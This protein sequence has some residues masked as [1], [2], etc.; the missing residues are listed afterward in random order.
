MGVTILPQVAASEPF[1]S[2]ASE[3]TTRVDQLL[4]EYWSEQDI[5]PTDASSDA[6]FIRRVYLDLV[7]TLPYPAELQE[8]L[9]DD[10]DD[11]RSQVI[12]R[13][14]NHPLHATHLA[15]TCARILISD[16]GANDQLGAIGMQDWLRDEFVNNT[17]FDRLVGNFLTVSGGQDTGPVIFYRLLELKPE[18]LAAATARSFLG[19]Q[20][21]CAECH[22]HPFVDTSQEDFWSFAA[23]L[24]VCEIATATT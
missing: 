7:G 19:L 12:E 18:K 11:K 23:F 4:A 6:E 13:L 20:L 15:N 16:G 17:R 22:D 2:N 14:L 10:A 8:F 3:M 9:D 21:Q 1:P 5:A 24:R